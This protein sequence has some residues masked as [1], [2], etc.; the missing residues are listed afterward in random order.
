MVYYCYSL[1]VAV[2]FEVYILL[3]ILVYYCLVI[4]LL[5]D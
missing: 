3:L 4:D 2:V 1:L 5:I